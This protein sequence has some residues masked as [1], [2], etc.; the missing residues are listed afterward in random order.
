[1]I[2]T[3]TP[4]PPADRWQAL[5]AGADAAD[6]EAHL[7]ACSR[8]RGLLDELA[9]GSSGWLR[10][11]ARLAADTDDD[12]ELTRSVHNI[13]DVVTDADRDVPL[14]FLSPSAVPGTIGMLGRYQVLAVLGRGATG[15]VL[16]ALDPDLLRPVAI[17][18]MIPYLAPNGTARQ[19]FQREARAAAAVSHDHVVTIHQVDENG[20][21]PFLVME[22][23][24]GG[25]LQARLDADG[26]MDPR[27]VAR[28]GLQ[29]AN[30]LAAAH[31][32]G[33]IHRDVKPANI[34][35]ENGVGRVKL[36]DFGL[37]RAADDV[38]LTQTGVAAGTPLYMSPEQ[39]RG[40]VIDH[41]SDLFSLGSVLYTLL[42]GVPPFRATTTMGVLN[43]I[44][45][46]APRPIRATTPDVPA[47][48]EAIVMQL[49]KKEPAERIPT[50]ADVAARL[51][52]FLAAPV[53]ERTETL[54]PARA[55]QSLAFA[56]VGVVGMVLIALAVAGAI[57][58]AAVVLT[59]RTPD[60]TLVVEV[61]DPNV[62]VFLDGSELTI[63]GAGP[64]E[65]RL[66]PGTYKVTSSK[67]GKS[68]AE[69][70]VTISRGDK[71]IVRVRA[72]PPPMVGPPAGLPGPAPA[73]PRGDPEPVPSRQAR[74][75][76][77]LRKQFPDATPEQTALMRAAFAEA[78]SKNPIVRRFGPQTHADYPKLLSVMVEAGMSEDGAP[79]LLEALNEAYALAT[80][81]LRDTAAAAKAGPPA[82][83]PKSAT[84]PTG[85]LDVLQK[86]FVDTIDSLAKTPVGPLMVLLGP[87]AVP[88]A[89]IAGM[90]DEEAK[91]VKRLLALRNQIG[92]LIP[93]V[94]KLE[95]QAETARL[96]HRNKE[97]K[98][99]AGTIAAHDLDLAR[100]NR[101]AAERALK[102]FEDTLAQATAGFQKEAAEYVQATKFPAEAEYKR[103]MTEYDALTVRL[104]KTEVGRLLATIKPDDKRTYDDL[105]REFPNYPGKSEQG[106]R[107][108]T[109]RKQILEQSSSA[110][111]A[112]TNRNRFTND[113]ARI[114]TLKEKPETVDPDDMEKSIRE[115][116]QKAK[117]HTEALR[118]MIRDFRKLADAIDPP[119]PPLKK[120]EE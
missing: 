85:R 29:A 9:A 22:Y 76:D 104:V 74:L 92:L 14:D 40:E 34:L 47:D 46:E 65:V 110:Q 81:I 73:G 95:H 75:A 12:P 23:V 71:T 21:L 36:T 15:I 108:L 27:E 79:R 49:L 109:L 101:T 26:P 62:K 19:R 69:E 82:A 67:D 35:L 25:S 112:I 41:R 93:Q 6:L 105:E 44:S 53:A 89:L 10:D 64:Q 68:V 99:E 39:A 5:L 2:Q 103:L 20:G 114:R 54:T 30:G 18:V 42:T 60:G 17:K 45:N 3:P 111:T 97:I 7:A 37:A 120:R 1:M 78:T 32:V 57:V 58:L 106:T 100:A 59:F 24:A 56:G 87:V 28:I 66:K 16:K 86:Q 52:A 117:F 43:R 13:Y 77:R 119:P 91:Q 50:A 118:G 48:L 116:E 80:R 102:T 72:A 115:D 51:T 70:I 84:P 55:W 94:Q 4:C 38:R 96:E 8:C 88:D 11:A 63:T 83:E 98:F 113:L 33:L 31:A 90:T 107:L 61:D